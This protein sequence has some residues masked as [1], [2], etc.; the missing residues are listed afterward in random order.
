MAYHWVHGCT[1]RVSRELFGAIYGGLLSYVP[2]QS[3]DGIY[4]YQKELL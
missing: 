3:I 2:G 1:S 4:G